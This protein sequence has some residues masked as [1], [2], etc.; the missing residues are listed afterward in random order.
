MCV[1]GG[2]GQIAYALLPMIV[3]GQVFGGDRRII[4]HLLDISPAISM[5]EGV[6]WFGVWVGDWVLYFVFSGCLMI[7]CY[8]CLFWRCCDGVGR[9][10]LSFVG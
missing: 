3:N 10:C 2:A 7:F 1:T 9:L 5:L 6:D 8:G 4:L